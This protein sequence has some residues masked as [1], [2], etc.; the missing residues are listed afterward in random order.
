MLLE[1]EAALLTLDQRLDDALEGRGALVLLEGSAGTGK[2]S[3]LRELRARATAR[4]VRVLR[5][6]GGEL[7]RDFPFGVVR[8]LLEPAV[9]SAGPQQRKRLLTGAAAQAAP[10][11]GG[12][13]GVEQATNATFA[14][15]HGLYWLVAGLAEDGPVVLVADDAHWADRPSLRFLDFLARRVAELPVLLAVGLRP[16]EPGAETDLL[17]ALADAPEVEVVHPTP[18]SARASRTLVAAALGDAVSTEVTEAAHRTTAG[19]PFL[20]GELVRTLAA[21]DEPATVRSV[22]DAVPSS[23][24]RS[25]RRRLERVPAVARRIAE[26]MAVLGDRTDAATLVA[27]A[28]LDDAKRR[29]G[30]QAMRTAELVE[31]DPPRFAHPLLAQAIAD[32]VPVEER[33]E[34]H[35][36]AARALRDRPGGEDALAAHLLA[37]PPT[38]EAWAVAALR[39]AA[40]AAL[41][42]GAPDAAVRPLAR[43]HE[44]LQ[45]AERLELALELGTAELMAGDQRHADVHLVEAMDSPE[46]SVAAMA[47]TAWLGIGASVSSSV[48]LER[49]RRAEALVDQVPS[50]LADALR[51]QILT[52]LATDAALTG[53]RLRVLASAGDDPPPGVVAMRAWEA[54]LADAPR[55]EV[56]VLVERALGGLPL[57]RAEGIA[58]PVVLNW[59]IAAGLAADGIP[60][61][62]VALGTAEAT[63]RRLGDRFA[64]G[65]LTLLRGTWLEHFGSMA[66][67]EECLRE[68]E[69]VFAP[70]GR[71]TILASARG[72]LARTLAWRGRLE[73]AEA[74]LASNAGIET[75]RMEALPLLSG[76]A[77]LRMAQGRYADAVADLEALR[78]VMRA[79]AWKRPPLA[80]PNQA[81]AL[82]LSRAGRPDEGRALAE[83]EAASAAARDLPSH[84]AEALTALAA[85]QD[86]AAAIATLRRAAGTA[87]RGPATRVQASAALELGAALRRSG[88]RSEAR[89]HLVAA[90]DLAHRIAADGLLARAT[91]E[92]ALAGG[93]P[94]RIA[95]SGRDSLTPSELRVAE[96]AARGLSNREIAETLFVT[97][98]TVEH[99]LGAAYA[100]LGIRSRVQLPEALSA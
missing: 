64:A 77:D 81:L 16:A 73:E 21:Q 65:F 89:A 49:V 8:Q 30:L 9:Q 29:E 10:I 95:T 90:R 20:L 26:V 58:L 100:K 55:A 46:P 33:H 82:A 70:A 18:L 76:R 79:F 19:N 2:S 52:G 74:V 36:A 42:A 88:E 53:E 25:V 22:Q 47:L 83:A 35:R 4:D 63:A 57:D 32:G 54:A 99:Q 71:S 15:L 84:E 67:A 62:F 3:L 39:A 13:P 27:V 68:A 17:T 61:A 51:A 96:H 87:A 66:V 75:S 94:R 59:A 40:Q 43:A 37:A 1:R 28:G 91:E 60:A 69:E 7:E 86:G 34:L 14:V 78:Q 38:T 72:V 6:T 80:Y 48:T 50:P 98:K 92:L 56:A 5:A 85:G 41:A 97:R 44:Q 31:D 93:R 24:A 12:G 11:V 45:G 23:V